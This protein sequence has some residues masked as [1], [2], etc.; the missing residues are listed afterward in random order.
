MA[1]KVMMLGLVVGAGGFAMTGAFGGGHDAERA[2]AR[3]PAEVYAAISS[4]AAAGVKES[5]PE[6]DGPRV[7]IEV[8]KDAGTAMHF[9][10]SS[11]G[12][13][14]GSLDLTVIPDQGGKASRLAADV[15]VDQRAM[16]KVLLDADAEDYVP[17]PPAVVKLAVNKMLGELARDIEAG[18]ALPTFDMSDV[19]S[20]NAQMVDAGRAG[21]MREEMQRQAAAPTAPVPLGTTAP[22]IDPNAEA[23]KYL[24]GG[25]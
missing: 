4:I 6:K 25:H 11:D 17:A 24:N 5:P 12:K 8:S 19:K 15:D 18:K 20:W 21:G 10:L 14:V 13:T 23:R 16:A 7:K 22:A 1:I 9:R 3:P 2:I